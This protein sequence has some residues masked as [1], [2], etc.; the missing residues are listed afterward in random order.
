MSKL[1]VNFSLFCFFSDHKTLKF[2]PC[3][4]VDSTD[5]WWMRSVLCYHETVKTFTNKSPAEGKSALAE[6]VVWL[7]DDQHR[8]TGWRVRW[9][10]RSAKPNDGR[11]VFGWTV[12]QRDGIT[13]AA[14]WRFQCQLLHSDRYRLQH[15]ECTTI[16]CQ[17]ILKY[18][19]TSTTR[20]SDTDRVYSL[21]CQV[22]SFY[23]KTMFE[24]Q[25]LKK[26]NSYKSS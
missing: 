9:V 10:V 8:W 6:W 5:T 4:V 12:I 25:Y 17:E 15:H 1:G 7:K 16:A 26:K 14:R 11:R 23:G 21:R 20:S 19:T 13:I 2:W 22:S 18:R 24:L 3:I